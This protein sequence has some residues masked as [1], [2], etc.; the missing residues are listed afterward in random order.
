M[1]PKSLLLDVVGSNSEECHLLVGSP[2]TAET[3][4]YAILGQTFLKD[5]VTAM[6]YEKTTQSFGVSKSANEGTAIAVHSKIENIIIASIVGVIL[7]LGIIVGF[8]LRYIHGRGKSARK[9]KALEKKLKSHESTSEYS[10][11]I[12]QQDSEF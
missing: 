8:C 6:D 4:Y 7:L 5:F 12:T 1:P 3:N 2:S 9:T 10:L 11:Q